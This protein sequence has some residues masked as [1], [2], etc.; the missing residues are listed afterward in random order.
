MPDR[1]QKIR[2]GIFILLIIL[3]LIILITVFARQKF[4]EK[5]DIYYISYKDI[6]VS[7]LEVGSPVKYLG[8][9]VGTIEDIQ[10]DP[11]DVS[12]VIIKVALKPGTPIKEDARADIA[13][14]GITGLKMLEIRGG[15][16][17]AP[18]LKPGSFIPA[19]SS[20]TAEI[21]GKAEIIAEKLEVVL[22]NL[23]V[24]TE[25]DNME[26]ILSFFDGATIAFQ[27]MEAVIDENRSSLRETIWT[28]R[29][30]TQRLDT[31]SQLLQLT[32]NEVQRIVASDTLKQILT[33][34]RDISLRLKQANLVQLI[35]EL[36]EMIDRT[37]RL[38]II[39]DNNL[40]RGSR[41]FLLSMRRMKTTLEFLNETSQML[42]DDPSILLRGTKL[43][44]IPDEQLD[45][46]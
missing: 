1:S 42:R 20:I 40:E 29:R 22:N 12:R 3:S 43:D 10:I 46:K 36:S 44:A 14:I 31:V 13:S 16:N 38:L 23:Q 18:L 39:M 8:I 26:K 34:T 7:G 32:L 21:T 35:D 4:L 37:N 2:F 19:G 45:K 11:K 5:E 6:S 24:M 33:S 25:K 17:E 27:K 41:D 15:S 30:T 28:T 9:K